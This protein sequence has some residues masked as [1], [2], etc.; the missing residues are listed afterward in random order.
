MYASIMEAPQLLSQTLHA[1]QTWPLGAD[2]RPPVD[3]G[4][5]TLCCRSLGGW[6]R[7]EN[8]ELGHGLPPLCFQ[9]KEHNENGSG[10]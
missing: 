9:F 10:A 2:G 5:S 4:A 1:L 7:F 3:R 8:A 6:V